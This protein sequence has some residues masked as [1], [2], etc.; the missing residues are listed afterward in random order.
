MTNNADGKNNFSDPNNEN[1]PIFTLEVK[2]NNDSIYNRSF[3]KIS[4][5]F[6]EIKNNFMIFDLEGAIMYSNGET[7]T[8]NTNQNELQA[9]NQNKNQPLGQP[10]VPENNALYEFDTPIT[11]RYSERGSEELIGI[12]PSKK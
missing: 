2:V 8:Q 12:I 6:G 3:Q 9:R 1:R 11:Y 5:T 10:P 4:T 7:G